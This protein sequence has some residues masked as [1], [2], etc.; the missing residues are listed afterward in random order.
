MDPLG[1]GLENYD[2]IGRY[3]QM[4]NG[5]PIDA[6]G[7]LNDGQ[8]FSGAQELAAILANDPRF[9]RCVTEKVYT[10]ALGRGVVTT[11]GH[12]DGEALTGITGAFNLRGLK[13]ASLVEAVTTAETFRF[14]GPAG[15]I[16]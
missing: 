4:E 12:L 11:P 13:F 1:F 10:Y 7:R 8:T 2:A 6:S 16:R 9:A 3:R 15:G 14:R 5:F